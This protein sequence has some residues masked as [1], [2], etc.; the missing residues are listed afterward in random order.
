[1]NFRTDLITE[2]TQTDGTL[3]GIKSESINYGGIKGDV[4]TVL[5]ENNK[6][7]KRKGKYVSFESEALLSRNVEE[8]I[9]ISKALAKELKK[10]I[11]P[12]KE[13]SVLVVGLGNESMT[14]DSVGPLTVK[15]ILVTRHIFEFLP[16]E[17]DERMNSVCAFSPGVL[18]VTGIESADIIKGIIKRANVGCVIVI[19]ALASRRSERMFSTFQITDTGIVP[20][21]GVGNKRSA[22]TKESLGIPVVAIGVPTVVY[23]SS[24]VYDAAV[25]MLS[26][27]TGQ[28][29]EAVEKA[30]KSI[31]SYSGEDMVV[32]PKEIDVIIKDSAKIISDGINL[33]L[34]DNI[35]LK[36]IEAYMF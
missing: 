25:E 30:A 28:G 35:S 15:N 16:N 34:H 18:G 9:K 17:I 1:V 29:E 20:G 11:K 5:D 13:K 24:L 3:T 2:A 4:V 26:E 19:D 21:A 31:A 33:A 7:G 22:L 12:E 8:Y 10:L 14:P 23:A 27:V 36:E 32:T 6:I